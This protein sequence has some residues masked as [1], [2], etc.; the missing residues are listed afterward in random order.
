MT[1]QETK[2]L[3]PES[4]TDN[5]SVDPLT[6]NV[7]VHYIYPESV[8]SLPTYW[9]DTAPLNYEV[10]LYNKPKIIFWRVLV[11]ST[12]VKTVN[13]GIQ[14]KYVVMKAY[15]STPWFW[16][17]ES[18]HDGTNSYLIYQ[19]NTGGQHGEQINNNN[20]GYYVVDAS[21]S[22]VAWRVTFTNYGFSFNVT[23]ISGGNVII[24][25]TAYS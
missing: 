18:Q 1:Q 12:W 14:P 4:T 19:S 5:P 11:S 23:S 15:A 3:N 22:S 6:W 8:P 21:T 25:Y 16:Y 7:D 13:V 24:H 10:A 17:S 2:W 20:S 9:R